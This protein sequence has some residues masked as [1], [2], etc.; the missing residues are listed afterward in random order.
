MNMLR[1]SLIEGLS[2]P[3]CL[4]WE[5]TWACN[6][7]CRHCLSASGVS[8]PRELDF[9]A[10]QKLLDDLHDMQV[11]YLNI[12]GG[13]PM[14][15]PQFFDIIEYA[16]SLGIGVKFSTNGTRLTRSAAQR[17]AA[18]TYCNVQVSLDGATAEVND[19]IRGVGSFDRALWALTNLAEV[20]VQGTKISVV[21]TRGSIDQLDD[22]RALADRFGAQLRLTRLRPSGRAQDCYEELALTDDEQR[23][24][25]DYLI[26]H[27]EIQTA[28][29]FFHLN[30]LGASL[31]GLNFCG[32]GRV[33]CLIDPVG[34]VYACPFTIHPDFL[35]GSVR[36]DR[37]ADI[38]RESELFRTLRAQP[39]AL[40]CHG[41]NAYAR[42]HGGCLAA[43]FFTGRS[44]EG[45]DPSCIRSVSNPVTFTPTR[46]TTDHTRRIRRGR[47]GLQV[48]DGDATRIGRAVPSD[49]IGVGLRAQNT[50]V[51]SV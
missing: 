40:G 29:S 35:A 26:A 50:S 10:C 5:L 24:L 7:S 8:D 27:P 16:D 17:I 3:L 36:S 44:L 51:G 18:L 34:D 12:G 38:W 39:P 46:N 37:F 48:A 15:H 21:V 20:G 49:D 32:A 19:A 42:C 11:F 33:V 41:C 14:M 1:D 6:L 2:S 28:D 4:T 45:A 25:Y 23:V 13:E 43:K 9:A 30:P 47:A 31:P 22:L